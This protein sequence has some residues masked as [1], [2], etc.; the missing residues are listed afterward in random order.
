[1]KAKGRIELSFDSAASAKS[2]AAA[3][4]SEKGFGRARCS[5][6][7]S[8][9]SLSIGIDADDT[10]AFRA[11]ANSVLRNLQVFESIQKNMLER[12]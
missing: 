1:M 6:K 9:S 2:A 8:G 12:V 5:V 4:E 10:V 11:A 3:L 7:L